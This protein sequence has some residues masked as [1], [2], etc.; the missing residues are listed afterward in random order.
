MNAQA[1]IALVT[2]AGTGIGKAVAIALAGEGYS[3]V[4]AGR[5]EE[6]LKATA[7]EIRR[8]DV[9][10]LIVPTDVGDPAAI[11]GLFAKTKSYF[12]RL[13]L[14][15]NNAG[16][17]ARAVPL[18]ELTFDEW[19]NPN[20]PLNDVVKCFLSSFPQGYG[21]EEHNQGPGTHFHFQLHALPGTKPRFNPAIQPYNP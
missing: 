4:L 6:L 16:I 19:K 3:L 1:K 14:L 9:A 8:A 13:D 15:F 7:T 18:E 2:G 11:R 17:S 10:A 5:R 20:L 21:Q 12:G